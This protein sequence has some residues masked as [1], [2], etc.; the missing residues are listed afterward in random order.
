MVRALSCGPALPARI[1]G[2]ARG[3]WRRFTLSPES[4]LRC[5]EGPSIFTAPLFPGPRAGQPI[6]AGCDGWLSL[7]LVTPVPEMLPP[8]RAGIGA[9][10]LP[11]SA[12]PG[13]RAEL[14]RLA[15]PGLHGRF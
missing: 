5:R 3:P 13:H 10:G 9:A 8:R 7:V 12:L 4:L 11:S 6:S 1:N 2:A 15:D 14:L